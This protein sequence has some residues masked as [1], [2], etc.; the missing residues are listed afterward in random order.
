MKYKIN[1]DELYNGDIIKDNT[2]NIEYRVES[3]YEY[4]TIMLKASDG[5]LLHINIEDINNG[6]YE[7]IEGDSLPKFIQANMKFYNDF[8]KPGI[9]FRDLTPVFAKPELVWECAQHIHL[10]VPEF[11]KIIALESRGF[12]VGTLLSQISDSELIMARKPGKL[13]GKLVRVNYGLEY[14]QN[15]LEIQ[16]DTIKPGDKVHIHDDILATGGTAKA[17]YD[18]V[19]KCGGIV[20]GFSFIDMV[21]DLNGYDILTQYAPVMVIVK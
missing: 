19:T 5:R 17:A 9:V 20:T 6:N 10:N 13:P 1:V 16:S 8:P 4:G 7:L 18:L 12:I 11:D 3:I 2:I 14:G 15:I 21:S